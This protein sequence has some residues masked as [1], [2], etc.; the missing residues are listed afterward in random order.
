MC[1][2][3]LHKHSSHPCTVRFQLFSIKST[4]AYAT[5][6]GEWSRTLNMPPT[7]K[8][9]FK[10][11][12]VCVSAFWTAFQ[13]SK[14]RLK[15][16]SASFS[17]AIPLPTPK[18]AESTMCDRISCVPSDHPAAPSLVQME[19]KSIAIERSYKVDDC[20]GKSGPIQMKSRPMIG[21]AQC[22]RDCLANLLVESRLKLLSKIVLGG[23]GRRP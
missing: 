15:Y 12:K 11:Q 10:T 5:N 22:Y 20:S 18:A 6:P 4:S 14:R 2:G 17:K 13:R 19:T 16:R 3:A 1:L 8:T 7:G 21:F 9:P 23:L